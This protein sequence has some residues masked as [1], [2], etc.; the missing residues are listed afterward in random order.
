MLRKKFA[1]LALTGLFMLVGA[2]APFAIQASPAPERPPGMMAQRL[3]DVFGIEQTE[4]AKYL[5][6][7]VNPRDILHAALLAKASGKSLTDVMQMKTLA[8]TWKEVRQSLGVT[9]EE[10]RLL[11]RDI[12]A[13][14]GEKI[15]AIPKQSTLVLLQQGYHPRDIVMAN[16]LSRETQRPVTDILALKQINNKWLDIAE[17]L[18]VDKET[19]KNDLREDLRKLHQAFPGFRARGQRWGS[20]GATTDFPG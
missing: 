9:P 4:A 12:I 15:L 2:L 17:Q 10:L 7:R 11:R 19:L 1:I 18:G 5:Q 6:Q 13:G 20:G 3:A 14:Q 16:I 8:N